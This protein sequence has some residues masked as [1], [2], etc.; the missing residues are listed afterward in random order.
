MSTPVTPATPRAGKKEAPKTAQQKRILELQAL[1]AKAT[2]KAPFSEVL[3]QELKT[4]VALER[5]LTLA[6]LANGRVN[7]V[8][9][10]M[11]QIGNLGAY[12]PSS[13]QTKMTFD[14]IKKS[15]EAAEAKWDSTI[16]VEG[17]GFSFATE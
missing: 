14:V 8:I 7:R 10:L 15:V 11:R 1:K 9:D 13:K 4:L 2:D 16:E 12:K 5:K 17:D 3:A 6:R